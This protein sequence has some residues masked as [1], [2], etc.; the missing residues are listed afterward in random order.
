MRHF[1]SSQASSQVDYP[2]ISGRPF[3]SV[4]TYRRLA[5]LFH[6][7]NRSR[8]LEIGSADAAIYWAEL[9]GCEAV[10]V[11]EQARRVEVLSKQVKAQGLHDQ[12]EVRQAAYSALPFGPGDFDG[13][14]CLGRPWMAFTEFV[15]S[16]R[17]FL[18]RDGRIALMHAMAFHPGPSAQARSHSKTGLMTPAEALEQLHLSGFE[19]ELA[20]CIGHHELRAFCSALTSYR[21]DSEEEAESLRRET[22]RLKQ[23]PDMGQSL[24]LFAARRKEPNESPPASRD[25]G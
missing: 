4:P 23:M 5:R 24:S 19:P 16:M 11:A 3:D 15:T 7:N 8:V 6:W 17:E 1:M 20:E 9:L 25:R 18:A 22:S 12:I 14:I 10:V 2:L 21:P 13:I